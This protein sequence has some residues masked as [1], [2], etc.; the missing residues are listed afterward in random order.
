MVERFSGEWR[1]TTIDDCAEILQGGTPDTKNPAYWGGNIIWVTPSEVTK[2]QSMYIDKSER[3]IT[4]EGLKHSSATIVPAGTILLC[5]R[6]TIGELAIAAKPMTTNQGFKNLICRKHVNNI[7]FA[8]LL[9]TL[10]KEMITLAAGTTFL[11]LSKSNLK[12]IPVTLPP[13]DEQIAIADTLSAFDRHL[14]NL[15]EL[16]AKHEG[17]RAGAL[18]DLVSGRTRL[19]GFSGEWETVK[20]GEIASVQDGTHGSFARAKTGRLLLSAKNVLDNHLEI[21]N[22]ERL[23]SQADYE[24]ITANGYPRVGDVLMCCVG[25]IGRCCVLDRDD[26]AFQ[27]SVAFIRPHKFNNKYLSYLI[28]SRQVQQ[29]IARSVNASAQGGIYLKALKQITLTLT[30]DVDEQIA[31][32]QTLSDLDNN[33]TNLKAEHAKISAIRS[34]A[35]NDLLTGKI[36]LL[37]VHSASML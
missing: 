2:L 28:Q 4:Q 36:R 19:P 33:I 11:E 9:K 10:K 31:I 23:V 8:Y 22:D 25:T 37:R 3:K 30:P 29:E 27:R 21:T 13:I 5:S 24:K 16:I 17:I 14:A 7:F 20:L 6:A 35:I 32:A 34:A 18:E 12:T 15:S 26:V 1:T